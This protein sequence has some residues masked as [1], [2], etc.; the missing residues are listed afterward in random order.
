MNKTKL[1]VRQIRLGEWA[2]IFKDRAAS[3]LT[4]DKYCESH[5][6]SV[7][8][9]YYWLRKVRESILDSQ[10]MELVEIKEPDQTPALPPK[11][12]AP[13]FR[14]EAIISFG[15][16]ARIEVNSSTP[17]QLLFALMEVAANVK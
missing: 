5:N 15:Q 17:K 7:N 10:H 14:T 4:V 11:N 9:Y 2:E 8:A 13:T 12:P 3:N 6:I 1:A 16:S